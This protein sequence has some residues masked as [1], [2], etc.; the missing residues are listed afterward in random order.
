M[1]ALTAILGSALLI[2]V[3]LDVFETIVLPR[4]VTRRLR[5]TA[6]FYRYTWRPYAAVARRIR[7]EKRREAFLGIYG[8]ASLLLLLGLWAIGVMLAFALLQFAA[9]SALKTPDTTPG[10]GTDVYFSAT[11]IFT[12]GLGDVVPMSP[13]SR[14]LTVVESGLGFGLLA[15]V[16]GYFPI[17]YQSFSRRET[18]V[19]MLDARAGTPPSVV[20]LLNRFSGDM[21]MILTTMLK[22]WEVWSAELLESHLSYPA[23]AY[24]RSQHDNQSWLASLAMILDASALLSVAQRDSS[25]RQPL[26][27]FA[28]ARHAVVD[29]ANIFRTPPH[30]DSDRLS[31]KTFLHF[32]PTLT[33]AGLRADPEVERELGELRRIYEPYLHALSQYLL[34]ALPPWVLP[35]RRTDN[36]L[37]TAWGRT[38]TPSSVSEP[39]ETSLE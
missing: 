2:L 20:V 3:L 21:N 33:L 7:S 29:L 4:R 24:F 8:P 6:I 10:F 27:T 36:W 1:T 35:A 12:L 13:I 16:I 26:L 14:F 23:L 28:M 11:T 18:H 31:H 37:T 19:S 22:E 38:S 34:V 5:P 30:P 32:Q 25:N 17:L 9:G 39:F 15:L